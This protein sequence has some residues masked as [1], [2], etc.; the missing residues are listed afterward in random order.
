MINA[1]ANI[2]EYEFDFPKAS[3]VAS[4]TQSVP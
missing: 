1:F 2:A 4:P 3:T